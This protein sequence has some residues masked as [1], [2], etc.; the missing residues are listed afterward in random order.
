MDYEFERKWKDLLTHLGDKF[1]EE[2]D[3]QGIL[4]LVGVQEL[5]MGFRKFKKDDKINLLHIAICTL[6]EP[7]GY[8]EFSGRDEDGWPHFEVLKTL[9][10]LSKEQQ[11]KL[12]RVSLIEYFEKQELTD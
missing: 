8:Y 2:L 11:D 3:L 12:M 1:G 9:P 4:F 10:P 6:L 7:Y 5:G